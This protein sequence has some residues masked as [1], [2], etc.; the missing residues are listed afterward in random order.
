MTEGTSFKS[1]DVSQGVAGEGS[2]SSLQLPETT[3]SSE[4]KVNKLI[5]NLVVQPQF[6]I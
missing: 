3:V 5:L 2:S 6:E 4:H 1:G